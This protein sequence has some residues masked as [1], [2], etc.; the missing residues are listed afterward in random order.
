[1]AGRVHALGTPL[2]HAAILYS[3]EALILPSAPGGQ[4]FLCGSLCWGGLAL[5]F[6]SLSRVS[7]P[8]VFSLFSARFLR[9]FWPSQYIFFSKVTKEISRVFMSVF[10]TFVAQRTCHH[11]TRFVK[12]PTASVT[13]FTKSLL[14]AAVL[15]P[16]CW[17]GASSHLLN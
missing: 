3:L 7:F 14:T 15:T 6:S 17:R 10:V 4:H 16:Q 9:R 2:R 13:A 8:A 5:H 11:N 12:P 1:M